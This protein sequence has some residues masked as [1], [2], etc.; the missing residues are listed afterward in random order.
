VK[1]VYFRLI[2]FA[3]ITL[4]VACSSSTSS[5]PTAP[6]SIT[7]STT[8]TADV[9]GATWRLQSIQ[10]DGRAEQAAP[11]G[12]DYS[13]TFADRLSIHADCNSCAS[14]YTIAGP[15]ITVAAGMACTRAACPTMA[16]ESEYTALLAG[17]HTVSTTA[18]SMVWTS[19][20]GTIRFAR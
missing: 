16:F 20:R 3:L 17:E 9:I 12:A 14:A 7:G 1:N 15:T 11:A 13:L 2:P 8:L 19:P 5:L 10:R 18:T 4:A 6:S